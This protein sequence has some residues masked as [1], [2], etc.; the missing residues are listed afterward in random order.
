MPIALQINLSA[1]EA[2]KEGQ[3]AAL[4]PRGRGPRTPIV[5]KIIRLWKV[6]L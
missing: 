3:G 6:D 5:K 2:K 1:A 4:D